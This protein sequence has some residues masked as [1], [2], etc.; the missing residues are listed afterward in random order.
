MPEGGSS[1]VE[2][3]LQVAGT[4]LCVR[5][6]GTGDPV[7]ILHHSTGS[8]GWEPLAAA[9][10]SS[11]AVIEPD[12]PGY[13]QS[14][15]PEWARS[16][17]DVAILIGRLIDHLDLPGVHVV[18][19]GFGGWVAAELATM[20][21]RRLATLTLVGAPGL[22]PRHG[23]IADQV[24]IGF[25]EYVRL[26]FSSDAAFEAEFGPKPDKALTELWDFSR[27][28]TARLTWKPWMFSRQLP[29]LLGEASMPALVVWGAED[30]VVPLDCGHQYAELLP[31]ARLEVV[32]AG[33][34]VDLE[35]PG[36]LTELITDHVRQAG[37]LVEATTPAAPVA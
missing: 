14:E 1:P 27:E 35:A 13:G 28:M 15:R 22:K 4:S 12:L 5:R 19:L 30:R 18:G 3:R 10:A 6:G 36:R 21:P 17:R 9:L 20:A 11:F 32:E 7:L 34:I 23:E 31:N 2:A 29:H 33:H 25:E 24:L 26:G 37:A 8:R 16:A